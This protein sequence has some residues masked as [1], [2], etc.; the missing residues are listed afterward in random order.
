MSIWFSG[1][2][3]SWARV[4]RAEPTGASTAN[5]FYMAGASWTHSRS[6]KL[7]KIVVR[8]TGGFY[9]DSIL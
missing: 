4:H 3:L 1:R 7:S 8:Q 9:M 2:S 5:S 6:G